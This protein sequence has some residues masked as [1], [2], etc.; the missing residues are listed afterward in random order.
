MENENKMEQ[1]YQTIEDIQAQIGH[2]KQLFEHVGPIDEQRSAK[3]KA[4]EVGSLEADEKTSTIEGVFDGQHMV[5]PDGKVYTM[6]ANYASKS[7]LVEGD[8]MKLTITHDGSFIY[9]QIGPVKRKREKGTLVHDAQTGM[10]RALT[11]GGKSYRLLTASVTYYKGEAGDSIILLVPTDMSSKWAAVENIVKDSTTDI[12]AD[13]NMNLLDDGA[14]GEL[15]FGNEI[16]LMN[17]AEAE[18]SA[19]KQ[20]VDEL[21]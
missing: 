21:I 6:P 5:G 14:H 8:I 15:P 11:S 20:A 16:E 13:P 19:P 10:F 4:I 1:I 3:E 9:K 12:Y 2:L 17:G 7:K 18:L